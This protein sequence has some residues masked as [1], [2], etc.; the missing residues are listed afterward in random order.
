MSGLPAGEVAD[1]V[2]AGGA[3]R[4]NVSIRGGPQGRQ[5]I[6]LGD[7]GAHVEMAQL[8]AKRAGHPAAT[9][10]EQFDIKTGDQF[11]CGLRAARSLER[12]LMTMPVHHT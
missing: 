12:F 5:Q 2:P 10:V 7:L 8:V 9:G 6:E 11:Q 3:R 4:G 1:L